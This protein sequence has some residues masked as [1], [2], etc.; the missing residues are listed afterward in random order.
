MTFKKQPVEAKPCS[1]A[2][3]IEAKL[4]IRFR[5]DPSKPSLQKV[6]TF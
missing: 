4:S 2:V 5:S 6:L 3:F 1:K